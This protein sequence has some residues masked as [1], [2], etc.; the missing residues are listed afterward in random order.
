MVRLRLLS[1]LVF[2]WLASHSR[3]ALAQEPFGVDPVATTPPATGGSEQATTARYWELGRARAFFATTLE[4]GY[5]YLRPKFALGYGL[6]YWRW[7]GLEAYPLVSLGGVGQYAGIG[8]ALPGVTFRVG[9]RYYLPFSRSFLLPQ[10]SYSRLDIES[11]AGPTADYLAL[12]AEVTGSIPVPAGTLVAVL[13]GY[14]VLLAPDGYFLYEDSLRAVMDPPWIWRARLGY[15]FALLRDGALRIGP[16]A[17]LIGLPGRGDFVVRG[18][19]VASVGINAHLEAQASVIPVIVS[20]DT[21]GLAGGDF[22]QLGIRL[23]WATG[24]APDPEKLRKARTERIE[25]LRRERREG[26]AP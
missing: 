16:A 3:A 23:R 22:G 4:A 1:I 11:L 26:A 2:A 17:D 20:P 25:E 13:T 6:P 18:G 12:E 24:S 10:D 8:G 15:L 9:G 14:H 19:L 21:L 5:A 7:I